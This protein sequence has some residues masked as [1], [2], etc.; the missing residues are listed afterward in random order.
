MNYSKYSLIDKV[1]TK[2]AHGY[3]NPRPG[4]AEFVAPIVSV[5]SRSGQIV[6]FGNEEFTVPNTKRAPG[7]TIK[8]E[9]TSYNSDKFSLTQ[10]ALAAEVAY[11][12]IEEAKEGGLLNLQRI[13]LNKVINKLML[14]WEIEVLDLVTNPDNFETTL[15]GTVGTKWGTAGS[16]PQMDIFEAKEAVRAQ[17]AVYPNSMVMG[18][19][20]HNALMTN[21]AIREQFKY[22][23]AGS[24]GLGMLA[25]YFDLERGIRVSKQV[26]AVNGGF[27]DIMPADSVLLFYAPTNSPSGTLTGNAVNTDRGTAS[28]CYTYT[29]KDYPQV[30][31][32][33]EDSNRRVLVASVIHEHQAVITGIGQTGKAGAGYLLTNVLS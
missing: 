9:G 22:T 16:D 30:T 10:D 12:H 1:F 24:I 13:S 28:F 4:V 26:K 27:V 20:V 33:V 6:R 5:T 11:E 2:L 19:A 31:P 18:A 14:G 23:T 21:A 15:T 17:S 25:E 29:H 7:A 8:R 32:W 3:Q